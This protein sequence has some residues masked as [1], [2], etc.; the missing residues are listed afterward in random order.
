MPASV[1][2]RSERSAT[3]L[4]LGYAPD[5][6]G[7]AARVRGPADAV[8]SARALTLGELERE[9]VVLA[10]AWFLGADAPGRASVVTR[11]SVRQI[12][13]IAGLREARARG[14]LELLADGGVLIDPAGLPL[15]LRSDAPVWDDEIVGRF[16][17]GLL[18]P[19]PAARVVRWD[20]V[21]DRASGSTR[22]L[23]ATAAFLDL[24]PVPTEWTSVSLAAVGAVSRYTGRKTAEAVRRAVECGVIEERRERG[25]ASLYRFAAAALHVP[26]SPDN[27]DVVAPG[28]SSDR[29]Q[30]A[31]PVRQGSPQLAVRTAP[32]LT[33]SAVVMR[34]VNGAAT[35]MIAGVPF[36]LPPG[37][38]PQLEQ[39]G[40]GRY[41]YR[42]GSMHLGPITFE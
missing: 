24:L 26:V 32:E 11:I 19:A 37:A 36:P 29:A 6:E 39:D 30:R 41:W 13:S 23:A 17:D 28:P 3:V 10:F 33:S 21:L 18:R 9:A 12:A 2:S 35:L 8:G 14:C 22:A 7:V 31:S 27:R 34:P 38:R 4:P 1:P 40:D 25:S 42:V 16:A 20:V 15:A 5:W